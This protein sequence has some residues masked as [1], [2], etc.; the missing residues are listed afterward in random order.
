MRW[1]NF[2]FLVRQGVASVWYNRMMSFASFCVLMVSLLLV[3]LALLTA[4]NV[5][6]ILSHIENRNE[7]MVF[8][9]GDLTESET[10]RISDALRKSPYTA[11]GGVRFYSKEASWADWQAADPD[12]AKIYDYMAD[13]DFNPMP[14]AFR[15]TINDLTKIS[16]A[17]DE[18]ENIEGVD[19]VKAPYDFA[20]FLVNMRATLTIIG[21][22]V[23]AALVVVCLIIVY[24]SAQASVFSRRQEIN[25]MKYVGATNSF[26]KIPFFIEGIFIGALAGAAA[27]GLTKFAYEAVMSVFGEGMTLWRA[28]GLAN[29]MAFGDISLFVLAA[30][31]AAG[32][33]LSSAGTVMSMGRHLKV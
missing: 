18:F 13:M 23:I 14:N 3:G 27:W 9:N 28:L 25:I 16:A 22:A 26:V 21:G 17:E 2:T 8:T 1:N 12:R 24:N 31:C 20:E 11:S 15:V 7:I 19:A 4:L 33:V 6:R 30:D 10:T 5:G 32:A 29:T